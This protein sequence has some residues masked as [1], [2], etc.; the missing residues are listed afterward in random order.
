MSIS[1]IETQLLTDLA[2][3]PRIPNPDAIAV[4]ATQG[5]VT[6]RGTVGS[7]A[8]RRAAVADARKVD[9]VED[10]VDDIDVRLQNDDMRADADI[11]GAALQA[12]IW[13]VEIPPEA[14]DVRVE[15]GW[16]FLEGE[17]SYQF[18]SD[19]AFADVASLTGVTGV[20]N[21]ITVVEPL[22]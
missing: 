22:L 21:S 4:E 6:L 12:L 18:E 15:G 7:F 9:G 1:T 10:V 13:D 17:V 11:R 20:T 16:V 19:R 14:I 5:I 2:S 3:D 8:Q